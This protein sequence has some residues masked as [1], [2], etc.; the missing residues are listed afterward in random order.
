[1]REG[2][3]GGESPS[4]GALSPPPPPSPLDGARYPRLS[5]IQFPSDLREFAEDRLNGRLR[6]GL[7]S[8]P[9]NKTGKLA[10]PK[11]PGLEAR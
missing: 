8:L 5:R 9:F 1:M 7:V 6:S 11:L 2:G 3:R 10:L 4:A